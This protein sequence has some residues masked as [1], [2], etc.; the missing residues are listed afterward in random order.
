[1]SFLVKIL[2]CVCGLLTFD[3]LLGAQIHYL[4][5]TSSIIDTLD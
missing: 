1:M 2:V 5:L 4:C 3:N